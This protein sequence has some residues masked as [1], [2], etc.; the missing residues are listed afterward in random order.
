MELDPEAR[1]LARDLL[2]LIVLGEGQIELG[3]GTRAQAGQSI[4]EILEHGTLA[5]HHIDVFALA[6]GKILAVDGP[7]EVD[8]HPIALG[9][10]TLHF[11]PG[12]SLLAQVLEH[13]VH[14][15]LGD[16]CGRPF[17]RDV[18]ES[19]RIELGHHLEGGGIL[20]IL[21]VFQCLGL[22]FRAA[23]RI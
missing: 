18:L 9:G 20:Q 21:P 4:L 2:D 22:D 23:Q 17:D 8:A 19:G 16:L 6:T 7:L 11:A 12:R 13:V 3:P 15:L 10:R 5:Q 1:G 14:I